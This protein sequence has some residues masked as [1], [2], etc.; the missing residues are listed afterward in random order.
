MLARPR[1]VISVTLHRLADGEIEGWDR[2]CDVLNVPKWEADDQ[3]GPKLDDQ[4]RPRPGFQ[5]FAFG[6]APGTVCS[7]TWT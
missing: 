6:P 3:G 2:L 5:K 4:G 1:G 7:T